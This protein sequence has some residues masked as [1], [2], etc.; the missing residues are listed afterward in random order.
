MCCGPFSI[1]HLNLDE[2]SPN[3]ANVLY[4]IHITWRYGCDVW[5]VIAKLLYCSNYMIMCDVCVK[6]RWLPNRGIMIFLF[7]SCGPAG[8]FLYAYINVYVDRKVPYYLLIL[9][10][11]VDCFSCR[12]WCC[13]SQPHWQKLSVFCGGGM[14]T[15][16]LCYH[17]LLITTWCKWALVMSKGERTDVRSVVKFC[18]S[19]D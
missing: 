9:I 10:N 5:F 15:F 8:T 12:R 2:V 11:T 1:K 18:W 7:V 3:K 4:F 6:L 13:F 16:C 14:C 17:F 19:E